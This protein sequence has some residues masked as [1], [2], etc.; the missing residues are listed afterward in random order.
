MQSMEHVN[1][2][3]RPPVDP[4]GFRKAID[5]RQNDVSTFMHLPYH[6]VMAKIPGVV[7][8]IKYTIE[9]LYSHGTRKF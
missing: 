7:A 5:I 9:A 1:L 2:G 3:Q 8:Q 6:Q 4:E